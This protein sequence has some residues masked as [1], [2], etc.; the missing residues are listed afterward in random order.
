MVYK[1]YISRNGKKFGPYYFKSVRGKN[2]KVKS[3]YLGTKDP[4]K[5]SLSFFG[6]FFLVALLFLAS[7]FGMFS[8]QGFQVA[9][10]SKT[11]SKVVQISILSRNSH[12]RFNIFS[13]LHSH[14]NDNSNCNRNN[15]KNTCPSVFL[16]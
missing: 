6:I 12:H 11:S 15:S 7:F 16:G 10:I 5:K 2:G 13:N 3:V 4:S 14:L 8:Y 1:K 9:E